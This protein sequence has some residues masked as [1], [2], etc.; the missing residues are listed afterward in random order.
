M[1]PQYPVAPPNFVEELSVDP[2]MRVFAP[3]N[4]RNKGPILEVLRRTM[5]PHTSRILEVACGT[6]QHAAFLGQSLPHISYFPT[7]Y[8]PLLFESVRSHCLGIHNVKAPTVLNIEQSAD[9]WS[10]L[11]LPLTPGSI[12]VIICINMTHISPWEATLGLLSGAESYLKPGSGRLLI[13]GPFTREYEFTS[14]SNQIFDAFLRSKDDKWGY[15]DINDIEHAGLAHQLECVEVV[16]MPANNFTLVFKRIE[17]GQSLASQ[18]R[19][20][21]EGVTTPVNPYVHISNPSRPSSCPS[22]GNTPIDPPEVTIL[23]DL[24]PIG[25]SKDIS[26][27]RL[28]EL[29]ALSNEKGLHCMIYRF[30]EL[31]P[32][33]TLCDHVTKMLDMSTSSSTHQLPGPYTYGTLSFASSKFLEDGQ[34]EDLEKAKKLTA[35]W[36]AGGPLFFSEFWRRRSDKTTNPADT[37]VT[38]TP[39]H[40]LSE[41]SAFLKLVLSKIASE[42]LPFVSPGLLLANPGKYESM[43]VACIEYPFVVS[44]TMPDGAKKRQWGMIWEV[45]CCY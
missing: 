11:Q 32:D 23:A 19:I 27:E 10:S 28:M 15:R 25:A 17:G 5:P 24:L 13:Y 1:T 18:L 42:H 41:W 6:G 35:A 39:H 20:S 26:M 37:A 30:S 16:S 34:M 38:I 8:L 14:A 9:S 45:S 21:M 33:E 22:S 3:S 4:E 44:T 12:D 7:D 43:P 29:Q 31:E 40:L 36:W 2:S